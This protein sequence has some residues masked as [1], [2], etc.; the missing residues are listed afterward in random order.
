MH[1]VLKPFDENKGLDK[2]DNHH[3]LTTNM[4][5]EFIKVCFLGNFRGIKMKRLAS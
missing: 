2:M 1:N 5:L 3:M 4:I